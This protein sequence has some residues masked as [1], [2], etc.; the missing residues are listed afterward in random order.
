VGEV[1]KGDRKEENEKKERLVRGE[2][3]YFLQETEL[4][5]ALT[6]HIQMMGY[7]EMRSIWKNVEVVP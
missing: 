1:R 5:Y 4:A 6:S 2:K 7:P 3:Y